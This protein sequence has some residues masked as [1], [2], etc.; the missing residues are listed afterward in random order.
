VI[1]GSRGEGKEEEVEK[2]ECEGRW[3]KWRELY[4]GKWKPKECEEG[5]RVKK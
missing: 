1:E 2:R 4:G 5:R 3:G